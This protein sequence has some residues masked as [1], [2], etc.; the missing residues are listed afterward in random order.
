MDIFWLKCRNDLIT[1][2]KCFC[3]QESI[4]Q[5]SSSNPTKRPNPTP[6]I[7]HWSS[8]S[9]KIKICKTIN[10]KKIFQIKPDYITWLPIYLTNCTILHGI[11]ILSYLY[12][13]NFKKLISFIFK[14]IYCK[15][16]HCLFCTN[17]IIFQ[18]C[19]LCKL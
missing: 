4:E 15:L 8:Q 12:W 9:Q 7:Q 19:L 16:Y 1:P 11:T 13:S 5:S 14:N 3:F 17:K 18:N 6:K 10:T 2:K